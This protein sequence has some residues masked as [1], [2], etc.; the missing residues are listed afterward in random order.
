MSFNIFSASYSCAA[1]LFAEQRTTATKI[2]MSRRTTRGIGLPLQGR[3]KNFP[4]ELLCTH[5]WPL[6]LA[7]L[8][9]LDLLDVRALDDADA[10]TLDAC[11][12]QGASRR[13]RA[14]A[15]FDANLLR[16]RKSVV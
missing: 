14:T 16:D 11:E 9:L 13:D 1:M 15:D 12:D 10:Q 7:L 3:A 2:G 4:L 5:R 8:D 6:P